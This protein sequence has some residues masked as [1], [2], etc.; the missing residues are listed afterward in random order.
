MSGKPPTKA[1]PQTVETDRDGVYSVAL[2]PYLPYEVSVDKPGLRA[3]PQLIRPRCG[4]SEA[5]LIVAAPIMS[6]ID[7]PELPTR[8]LPDTDIREL[9]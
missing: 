1:R 9:R 2:Q 3:E 7:V 6:R 8:L 4:V 5:N